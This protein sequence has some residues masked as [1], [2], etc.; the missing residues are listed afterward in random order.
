MLQLVVDWSRASRGLERGRRVPVPRNRAAS[1]DGILRLHRPGAL[2]P[3]GGYSLSR[4][5]MRRSGISQMRA[6]AT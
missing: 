4:S 2:G 3:A 6:T 5:S 1:P